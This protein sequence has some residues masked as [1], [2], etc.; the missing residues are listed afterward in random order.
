MDLKHALL[1]FVVVLTGASTAVAQD[2]MFRCGN[3][4]YTNDPAA[5]KDKNC[6]PI[7]GN[8]VS[9]IPGTAVKA[10]ANSA[11]AASGTAAQK[12]DT[13]DQRARDADARAVLEAE[14]KR[15]EARRAELLAEY[16]DGKPDQQGIESRNQQRYLD[17]VAE[18]KAAIAR[19][20]S[21]IVGIRRELGRSPAPAPASAPVP[22]APVAVG[23]PA[24]AAK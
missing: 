4:V 14:L 13:N 22:V 3:N 23:A 1:A 6:R 19:N 2:R 12:V 16:K 5:A 20:E 21:D 7:Q 24:S 11:P 15:A 9:V 10:T 8:N 17:R 18:L